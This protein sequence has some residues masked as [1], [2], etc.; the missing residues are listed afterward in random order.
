MEHDIIGDDHDQ[1]I[2]DLITFKM[3]KGY[4]KDRILRLLF[5]LS[6]TEG[7]LKE[8]HYKHLLKTYIECYGIEDLHTILGA[9]DMG[10]FWKKGAVKYDWKKIKQEFQLINVD[11][12][13]QNPVDISFTYNGY[14]PLSVKIVEMFIAGGFQNIQ[15]KLRLLPGW[16][17]YPHNEIELVKTQKSMNSKDKKRIVVVFFIG[18]VTFAEISAIRFLNKLTDKTFVILTTETLNGFK[19]IK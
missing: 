10:I 16:M 18:G 1:E 17:A 15:D 2:L 3:V 19:C 9:E 4:S 7:G 13:V 6:I 14:A 5:L 12:R 11:I 8:A